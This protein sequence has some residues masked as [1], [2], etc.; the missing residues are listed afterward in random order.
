[1]GRTEVLYADA[2]RAEGRFAHLMQ[3]IAEVTLTQVRVQTLKPLDCLLEDMLLDPAYTSGTAARSP[4]NIVADASDGG[5]EA[6]A[7][8]EE[9][10]ALGVLEK[11]N[12]A[13]D[14]S[15]KGSHAPASRRVLLET[16]SADGKP[17]STVAAAQAK[18]TNENTDADANTDASA[19]GTV[20]KGLVE[21]TKGNG[22]L[23]PPT[24]DKAEAKGLEAHVCDVLQCRFKC[25]KMERVADVVATFALMQT[26]LEICGVQEVS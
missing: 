7:L 24:T 12:Q 10:Q 20:G 25:S 1:M 19:A 5:E 4:A 18:P 9:A 23:E 16:L 17:P 22:L 11:G 6:Q 26:D 3:R 15:K 2:A 8:G 21:Q 13:L 14:V